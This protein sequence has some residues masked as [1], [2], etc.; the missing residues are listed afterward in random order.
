MGDGGA[1]EDPIRLQNHLRRREMSEGTTRDGMRRAEDPLAD[2]RR[3]G[4]D[5]RQRLMEDAGDPLRLGEAAERL[6]ISA[7]AVT[8]RRRRGTIFA[9]PAPTGEWVFP[10]CQLDALA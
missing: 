3:R 4:T 8:G 2:A 5:A 10:A 7:R 6:G 1:A 9:V